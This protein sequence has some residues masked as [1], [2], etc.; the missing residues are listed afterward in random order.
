MEIVWILCSHTCVVCPRGGRR[1]E[2]IFVKMF[3]SSFEKND[4][5]DR[6]VFLFKEVIYERGV[7]FETI[8]KRKILFNFV[9][10]WFVSGKRIERRG[11]GEK[12]EV[13]L[14]LSLC[15]EVFAFPPTLCVFRRN[16][17]G[18]WKRI[19]FFFLSLSPP[20]KRIFIERTSNFNRELPRELQIGGSPR[21]SRFRAFR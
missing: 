9:C 4:D 6:F 16:S 8:E 7:P 19:Y 2:Q 15:L 3:R 18:R 5:F 11:V 17:R 20:P 13:T 14:S 1:N 21:F 12:R 10:Q